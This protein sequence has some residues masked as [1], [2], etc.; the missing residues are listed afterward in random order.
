MHGR[1]LCS[2]THVDKCLSKDW[3]IIVSWC[4]LLLDDVFV[5]F[6]IAACCACYVFVAGVIFAD[7]KLMKVVIQGTK[8]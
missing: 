3:R 2:K 7:I 1:N 8:T 4:L 5:A 6:L